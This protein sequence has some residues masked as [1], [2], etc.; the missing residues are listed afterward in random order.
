MLAINR[1]PVANNGLVSVTMIAGN[2][3]DMLREHLSLNRPVS[4]YNV[5]LRDG[6]IYG[7]NKK[8]TGH[9]NKCTAKNQCEFPAHSSRTPSTAGHAI[10]TAAR[11]NL[12]ERN[13]SN[14]NA[15]RIPRLLQ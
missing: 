3:G 4:L 12:D 13:G 8:D 5:P 14:F 6:K 9:S 2:R 10:I 7:N 15:R 1:V 11:E